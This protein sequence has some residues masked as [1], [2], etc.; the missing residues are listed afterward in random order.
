M[1]PRVVVP[2]TVHE[3]FQVLQREH[4]MGRIPA[5]VAYLWREGHHSAAQWIAGHGV[6]Y[7][8][9]VLF[10][11]I[12]RDDGRAWRGE[13]LATQLASRKGNTEATETKGVSSGEEEKS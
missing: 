4:I 3:A 11:Y 10:G 12:Y 7:R 13:C 1:I 5:I 2:L 9:A 8:E 6:L